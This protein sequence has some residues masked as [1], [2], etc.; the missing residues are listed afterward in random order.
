MSKRR[1]IEKAFEAAMT[2]RG[3]L[4]GRISSLP[5]K[6]YFSDVPVTPYFSPHIVGR[7]S[8]VYSING[9]VGVIDR[10]FEEAWMKDNP[11]EN[12][13][14]LHLYSLNIPQLGELSHY[15]DRDDVDSSVARFAP[16]LEQVLR[17]MP[18][19]RVEL[20]TAFESGNLL[21]HKLE[22]FAGRTQL[23]PSQWVIS[24]KYKQFRSFILGQQT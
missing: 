22:S 10:E 19:S 11:E 24:D 2:S 1:E 12:G 6:V 8:G 3:W 15:V 23:S 5:R 13:P 9:G 14:C 16:I 17:R 4:Y 21:G 18:H 7:P 20:R